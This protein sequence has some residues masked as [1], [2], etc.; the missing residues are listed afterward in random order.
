MGVMKVVGY[1]VALL[2]ALA[3]VVGGSFLIAVAVTIGGAL[4]ALFALGTL[5]VLGTREFYETVIR[6]RRR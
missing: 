5:V 6:R 1:I 4:T 2:L 3:V